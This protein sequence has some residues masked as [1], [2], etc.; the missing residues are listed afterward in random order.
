MAAAAA[1]AAAAAT[2]AAAAA[3]AGSHG[4]KSTQRHHFLI[5][6]KCCLSYKLKHIFFT[7]SGYVRISMFLFF[8][9]RHIKDL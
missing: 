3:A 2:V 4:I 5:T 6:N 8:I 7:L 1:A 9:K